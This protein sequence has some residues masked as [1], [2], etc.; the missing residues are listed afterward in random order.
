MKVL[1]D[2][3]SSLDTSYTVEEIY[4]CVLW[5]AVK[6]RHWGLASSLHQVHPHHGKVRGVGLN[7]TELEILGVRMADN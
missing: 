4:S 3:I 7:D 5:T 1:E 6:T 2:L